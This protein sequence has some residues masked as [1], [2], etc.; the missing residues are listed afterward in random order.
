MSQVA[1]FNLHL[2]GKQQLTQ[3][4][5]IDNKRLALNRYLYTLA[6]TR[7]RAKVRYEIATKRWILR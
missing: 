5:R 1:R 2:R 6:D 4:N 3:N 7:K